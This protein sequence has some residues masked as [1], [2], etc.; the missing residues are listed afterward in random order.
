MTTAGSW[1]GSGQPR[2]V[3]ASAC[4][5]SLH[6]AQQGVAG[7][8][9]LQPTGF[10]AGLRAPGTCSRLA[11]AL[12]CVTEGVDRPQLAAVVPLSKS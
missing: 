2:T 8:C 7:Q 4:S 11:Q 9:P 1:A 12:D 6:M 10:S 3:C 5:G